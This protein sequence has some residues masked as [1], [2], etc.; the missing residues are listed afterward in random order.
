[1]TM[2]IDPV[3]R[4]EAAAVLLASALGMGRAGAEVQALRITVPFSAGT[5][6]DAMARRLGEAIAT[7]TG[8][9]PVVLNRD[10]AA[11][12]LAFAELGHGPTDGSA[13]IFGPASPLV[14]HP[15]LRREP[16]LDPG[17][18]R[19]VCQVF[20][21][22]LALVVSRHL[23]VG[24]VA[25][26]IELARKRVGALTFG[27]YG[28]ASGTHVELR[29]FARAAGLDVVEVP[30][31][32]HGQ[33]IADLAAGK[34]D[35]AIS[36]PGT[37]DAGVIQPLMVIAHA[38]IGLYPGVPASAAVGFPPSMP[39]FGGVFAPGATADAIVESLSEKFRSAFADPEFQALAT[40]FGVLTRFAGHDVF[41]ARIK[42]E[43][44][45]AQAL[46][47][48]LDIVSQ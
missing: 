15:H 20:D 37:F 34:L 30:Y 8:E 44:L 9:R 7:A 1:M 41:A 38:P 29:A 45:R 14:V 27:H 21:Q 47:V 46:L 6:M 5:V 12:A 16:R 13:V 33:L 4:R 23:G 42:E 25:D 39:I 3:S 36:T 24:T 18:F 19:P 2:T 22:P 26:L 35:A 43:S 11:G 40:R 31:R 32:A 28:Q 48:R 10:G 17:A